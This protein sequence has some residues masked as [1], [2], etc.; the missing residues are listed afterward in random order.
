[1]DDFDAWMAKVDAYLMNKVGLES[2]D[3]IDQCYRDMFE[4]GIPPSR[5]AMKALKAEGYEG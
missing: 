4:D 5:A 2:A 1:M 3:L